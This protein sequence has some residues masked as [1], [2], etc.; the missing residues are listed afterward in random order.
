M[1]IGLNQFLNDLNKVY[2]FFSSFKKIPPGPPYYWEESSSTMYASCQFRTT[3]ATGDVRP[4]EYPRQR[5]P[6]NGIDGMVQ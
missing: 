1:Q 6:P 5:W 4:V 3:G 2:V